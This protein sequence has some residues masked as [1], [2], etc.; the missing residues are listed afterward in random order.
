MRYSTRPC[1]FVALSRRMKKKKSWC[2]FLQDP[3][4]FIS[5][6]IVWWIPKL[7]M[8]CWHGP[9]SMSKKIVYRLSLIVG[10]CAVVDE[11]T[12]LGSADGSVCSWAWVQCINSY[13]SLWYCKATLQQV[14]CVGVIVK[15]KSSTSSII[16]I[17]RAGFCVGVMVSFSF[18]VLTGTINRSASI[19]YMT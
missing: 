3:V 9:D 1:W 12:W 16:T 14:S 19:N 11:E 18:F 4:F 17:N 5:Q 2:R 8:C 6:P 15:K 10:S 7:L 13:W